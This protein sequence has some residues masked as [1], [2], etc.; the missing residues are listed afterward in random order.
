MSVVMTSNTIYDIFYD[1]YETLRGFLH[2]HSYTGNALAARVALA[3]LDIFARDD[4]IVANQARSLAMAEALAPLQTHPHIH[5]I[6]QTG[7]VAAF[8]LVRDKANGIPYDWRER[9]GLAVFQAALKRGLLLRPIG[10]VV[11]FM[12]P[13]IISAEQIRWMVATA[14]EAIDEAIAGPARDSA[15]LGPSMA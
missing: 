2:S 15:E 7:M 14:V 3:S 4:V 6:R 8:D 9:R 11:Y 5:N 12:P 10:N 1:N 13:Y